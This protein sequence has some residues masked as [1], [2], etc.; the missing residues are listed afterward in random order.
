MSLSPAFL[1]ELRAR[2]PVSGVVGRR[3]KLTR[4]GREMKGCCPFHNEKTPSFYVNDDKGFYHCFG[5][6]V[7]GDVIRFLTDNMG[8]PFMEAVKQLAAEAGL[9]VPAASPEAREKARV[10]D[11]LAELT[12]RAGKWFQAQLAG[13]AGAAARAYLDRRGVPP[14]LARR[15]GLGFAL[16]G[17]TAL[18]SHFNDVEADKLL[19]AGLIGK[20]EQGEIF[21]R[22]RGRLMFPIRDRRGRVVGFGGRALG[23][24]QPKYL[25][26]ADGPLFD[27]GRLLYNLDLAGP[28]ARQKGRLI[29]VE[30]YMDVI[31]LANAG[32]AEAVAP[33]GTAMTEAQ[34]TLAW[35]LVNEPLLCFDGDAA[36]LRAATRAAG[37]ALPLL[38]PG[39][40][41]RIATLP[42]GQDP[43]DLC[44]AG[45]AAAFEAVLN[46]AVPLIDHIWASES[47]GLE[48]ATPERRAQ[49]RTR[50][51]EAAASI[52][53]PDVRSLYQAEFNRRF[54]A[55]FLSRPT[56]PA[57]QPRRP[58]GK[59]QP[60]VPGAS[61]AL[62]ALVSRGR[63]PLLTAV[64]TGLLVRPGLADSHA[65]ALAGLQLDDPDEA[66]L[67]D[68]VL[69]ATASDQGLESAGLAAHLTRVGLGEMARRVQTANNLA[70][71]FT[72]ATAAADIADT[73][74]GLALRQATARSALLVGLADATARFQDSLSEAD[75]EA[76]Q[77][78]RQDMESLDAAMM[79]L[80][81]SRR[82]D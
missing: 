31:G 67:L 7:H 63:D 55:A 27:K 54:E 78:L 50:L 16:D 22:F 56:R 2:V 12:E 35:R 51:R 53:D 29:V 76:Q 23:D 70:F 9:E 57:W 69:A 58:G 28:A 5:C 82:E 71:S 24:V 72:Q 34:L 25:N 45:G 62:K 59:W 3:V 47:A 40:S 13:D 65:D 79:K 30:G 33:L 19:E 46:A 42:A 81:E 49:A 74:F 21:D 15:F 11:S 10:A 48:L 41:L 18:R 80:V 6:G 60:P 26:S 32:I 43:D 4:A 8:L 64:L 52:A 20:S 75:F 36:G 44:R 73:D 38:Q 39:K 1:D 68:E 14:D 77:A 66:A 61:A 37:R 17:R